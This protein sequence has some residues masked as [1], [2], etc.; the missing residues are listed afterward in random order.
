[1][2]QESEKRMPVQSGSE[3]GAAIITELSHSPD[4]F[5]VPSEIELETP[6]Y[7]SIF[8]Q[9]QETLGCSG[10]LLRSHSSELVKIEAACQRLIAVRAPIVVSMTQS[11]AARQIRSSQDMALQTAELEQTLGALEA[12]QKLLFAEVRGVARQSTDLSEQIPPRVHKISEHVLGV[13]AYCAELSSLRDSGVAVDSEF[14]EESLSVCDNLAHFQSLLANDQLAHQSSLRLLQEEC[15]SIAR[16]TER[17]EAAKRQFQDAVK[18]NGTIQQRL[19]ELELEVAKLASCCTL[20]DR[21]Q[22]S[23]AR[24]PVKVS[25]DLPA[26]IDC[27][28]S[29]LLCLSTATRNK[30]AD[31]SQL[32]VIT[33]PERSHDDINGSS[34]VPSLSPTQSRLPRSESLLRNA[35]PGFSLPDLI[36]HLTN[37]QMT[38]PLPL[39]HFLLTYPYVVTPFNLLRYLILRFCATPSRNR[40]VSARQ[41]Q[42]QS[43]IRVLNVLKLWL[44]FYP[45][46]FL[47]SDTAL[48][49]LLRDFLVN[50]VTDSFRSVCSKM[51]G[52][53]EN[54]LLKASN[55]LPLLIGAPPVSDFTNPSIAELPE[56][57]EG[58]SPQHMFAAVSPKES[59]RQLTLSVFEIFSH[60]RR[61]EFLNAAW[62]KEGKDSNAPHVQRLVQDFN[63]LSGFV[64][65]HILSF[66]SFDKRTRALE[67][68]TR[69]AIEASELLNFHT[70]IAIVSALQ[71]SSIFRLK[72]S[73]EALPLDLSLA[74]KDRSALLR[75]NS[76]LLRQRIETASAPCIPYIGIYLTDLTFLEDGNPLYLESGLINAV[77]LDMI[78]KRIAEFMSF[79]TPPYN[80]HHLPAVIKV[81]QDTSIIMADE[82]SYRR[83]LQLEPP[84]KTTPLPIAS[85]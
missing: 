56:L 54:A 13:I 15:E 64:V 46:D 53:I 47:E 31:W 1:M 67:Y 40:R 14:I 62:S 34:R 65:A 22:Q 10:S 69:L 5:P 74:F 19:A 9:E 66:D 43:Q 12:R 80:F 85:I 58:L 41:H 81:F 75:D 82:E 60:L 25:P 30:A 18:L 24:Q 48:L 83:S 49:G 78:G 63:Q 61:S 51:V 44:E 39:K 84:L 36:F 32:L 3:D 35:A 72:R 42:K 50:S 71:H 45:E 52:R 70:T 28:M 7:E 79:R 38:E 20:P 17:L 23:A 73:W 76:K 8:A 16:R 33:P 59:A 68:C 27:R 26:A 55:Q 21:R 37:P 11:E 77:K 29:Q 6:G 4:L 57:L 2:E